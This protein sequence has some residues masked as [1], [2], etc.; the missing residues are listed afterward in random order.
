MLQATFCAEGPKQYK[1]S[2]V[3]LR[4]YEEKL[5]GEGKCQDDI[6]PPRYKES[7]NPDY[8]A[9]SKTVVCE[10]CPMKRGVFKQVVDEGDGEKK[11]AHVVCALWQT[12]D[13]TVASLN[14]PDM[15]RF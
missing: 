15:V 4:R 5:K 10:L 9:G 1:S 2:V 7:G 13:V 14:K 12:P 8:P 6:R 3:S 11:W